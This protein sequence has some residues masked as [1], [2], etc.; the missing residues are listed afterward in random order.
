[1]QIFDRTL[2]NHLIFT[3]VF[4]LFVF[5]Y[6]GGLL[7]KHYRFNLS[8]ESYQV[9]ALVNTNGA[10]YLLCIYHDLYY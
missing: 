10:V 2:P 9:T 1:M 8:Q 4:A 6:W 5:P 7:K 3:D